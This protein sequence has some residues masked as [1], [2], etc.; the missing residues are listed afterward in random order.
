FRFTYLLKRFC[1]M[2][3]TPM[4]LAHLL[5][6]FYG[7]L[8]PQKFAPKCLT[9]FSTD[10]CRVFSTTMCITNLAAGLFGTLK[11]SDSFTT[12]GH[13]IAE[14][15]VFCTKRPNEFYLRSIQVFYY[16]SDAR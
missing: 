8:S 16:R 6:C 3:S 5:K 11:T 4:S 1:R 12:I 15:G 7:M 10:F 2:P 14:V 9:P 13:V